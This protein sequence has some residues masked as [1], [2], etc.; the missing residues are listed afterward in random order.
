MMKSMFGAEKRHRADYDCV[1]LS[2]LYD[3]LVQ[4]PRATP[5]AIMYLPFQG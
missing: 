2:G 3:V 5:W 4:I 1:A